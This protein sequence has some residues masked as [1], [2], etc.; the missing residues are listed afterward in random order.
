MQEV[1]TLPIQETTIT[2]YRGHTAPVNAVAWST[3]ERHEAAHY[4]SRIASGSDDGTVQI[5]DAMT[6]RKI[7]THRDHSGGVS[8]IAWSPGGKWIASARVDGIVSRWTPATSAKG[9]THNT[10]L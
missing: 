9:C 4:G 6:G 7:S 3:S 8:T 2:T 5:W 1:H 10:P